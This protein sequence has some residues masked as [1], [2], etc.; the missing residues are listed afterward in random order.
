[1]YDCRGVRCV[2]FDLCISDKFEYMNNRDHMVLVH[3]N[4][5]PDLAEF[6][7]RGFKTQE[8]YS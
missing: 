3:G 1:M 7:I 5:D 6:T 4:K 8:F 2:E